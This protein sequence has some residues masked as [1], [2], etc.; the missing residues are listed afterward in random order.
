MEIGKEHHLSFS[1]GMISEGT[2]DDELSKRGKRGVRLP[3]D[4]SQQS[5]KSSM[6]E[7][8]F[9]ALDMIQCMAPQIIAEVQK[10]LLKPLLR[11]PEDAQERRVQWD[12]LPAGHSS[13][14]ESV[15]VKEMNVGRARVGSEERPHGYHREVVVAL[16]PMGPAHSVDLEEHRDQEPG[17]KHYNCRRFHP[18][19]PVRQDVTAYEAR[20]TPPARNLRSSGA[21][22]SGLIDP[23][24]RL[25][26]RS[27][28]FFRPPLP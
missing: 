22:T 28:A 12:F 19:D 27:W 23:P 18:A 9:C 8:E 2:G 5:D 6:E 4:E 26:K 16:E 1:F 25:T 11:V 20:Q 10:T 13:I 14:R 24:P 3:G 7:Y 15:A 17:R 21:P